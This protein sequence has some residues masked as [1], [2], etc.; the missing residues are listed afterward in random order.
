M[1]LEIKALEDNNTCTL[2]NLPPG[3]TAIGCKRIYKIKHRSD[4]NMERYK[5]RL[6]GKGFTQREGFVYLATF[7][8][9]A[10]HKY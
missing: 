4:G 8:P 1:K 6:V 2:T 3:K 7:S 9:V 5:A 10:Y